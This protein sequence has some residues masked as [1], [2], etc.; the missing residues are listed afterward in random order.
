MH[1]K[2]SAQAISEMVQ[3]RRIAWRHVGGLIVA[4]PLLSQAWPLSARPPNTWPGSYTAKV[5][6]LALLQSFNADLLSHD[7]ATL[8]LE[9]WC[10]AH[11]MAVP[12]KITAHVVPGA[13]VPLPDDLRERLK[14]SRGEE[15]KHRQVELRCGDHT[16][17]I[18]DN[19]YVPSRLTRAMNRQLDTTT[20]P[21]GKVVQPLHFRRQTLSA[22]MLWSPLPEGW[23]MSPPAEPAPTQEPM[24]IPPR[25]LQHRAILYSGANVP[26]SAVRE[27]YTDQVLRFARQP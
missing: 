9:R 19:W 25:I 23:E 3:S 20:T 26:F 7:S 12:P 27:T 14:L 2:A 24:T 4:L 8:T 22:E 18:A 1:R 13:Q 5:E 15:V 11:A 17:S 6:A 10:G 16:L 21:F